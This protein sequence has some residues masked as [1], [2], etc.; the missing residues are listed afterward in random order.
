M[1]PIDKLI[2]YI[3]KRLRTAG[4]TLSSS[5]IAEIHK[6]WKLPADKGGYSDY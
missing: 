2:E 1:K 3:N 4:L 6:R 5:G